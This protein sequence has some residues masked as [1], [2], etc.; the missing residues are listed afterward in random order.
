M[1]FSIFSYICTV[2]SLSFIFAIFCAFLLTAPCSDVSAST[3]G[4][5]TTVQHDKKSEKQKHADYCSPFCTCS[6]CGAQLSIVSIEW[7]FLPKEAIFYSKKISSYHSLFNP[8][9]PSGI[10]QPPQLG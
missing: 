9:I 3:K 8:G 6:C 7:F 10:W 1:S 5:H 2:R 4:T